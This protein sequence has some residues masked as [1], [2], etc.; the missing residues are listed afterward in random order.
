MS[1]SVYHVNIT[2]LGIGTLKL[3]L[4]RALAPLTVQKLTQ[5]M[6]VQSRAIKRPKELHIPLKDIIAASEHEKIVFDKG[7]VAFDPRN[8]ELLIFLEDEPS[9]IE[10]YN[11]V[12]KVIS[13][14]DLVNK[15][16][17]SVGVNIELE[18]MN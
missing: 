11:H 15:A 16:R 7:E 3:E 5:A 12:G 1:N 10:P 13:G 17:L 14:L 2:L 9:T 4:Y 8:S 6:P 18:K